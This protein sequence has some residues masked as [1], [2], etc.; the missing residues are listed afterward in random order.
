MANKRG[1]PRLIRPKKQARLNVE[2]LHLLPELKTAISPRGLSMTD[3]QAIDVLISLVHELLVERRG[4]MC[5]PEKL[6]NAMNG[7]IRKVFSEVMPE[8]LEGLGHKDVKT[9]YAADGKVTVT[10]D[11]GAARMPAEVFTG[12]RLDK[13]A[14]LRELKAVGRVN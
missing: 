8:I 1:R 13:D 9:T 2:Y 4:F 10:C 5:D 14:L 7:Q 11:T 12:E 3:A 6:L